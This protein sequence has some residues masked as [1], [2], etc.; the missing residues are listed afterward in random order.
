MS[1]KPEEA[2]QEQQQSEETP[3]LP[4]VYIR[5]TTTA[6]TEGGQAQF[7]VC[8]SE[9][10]TSDV[11]VQWITADGTATAGSDYTGVS[12]PQTLTIRAGWHNGVIE[13]K[14]AAD[15]EYDRDETFT[16]TLS[17]PSGATLGTAITGT[18]TII[19]DD[20]PLCRTDRRC[21]RLRE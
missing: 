13:V 17:N 12:T 21:A 5:N 1:G 10:Q 6:G 2:Q 7:I 14:V 9:V 18:A 16:V 20:A 11:T 15:D 19:D 4:E 3:P 8:L